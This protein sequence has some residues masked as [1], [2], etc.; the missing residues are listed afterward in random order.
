MFPHSN[1]CCP[2]IPDNHS[3]R[4]ILPRIV[5]RP[6]VTK[7][8][9]GPDKGAGG[10]RQRDSNSSRRVQY[11]SEGG[12]SEPRAHGEARHMPLLCCLSCQ[13]CK[14]NT[15]GCFATHKLIKG[16]SDV[17]CIQTINTADVSDMKQAI[18]T[19]ASEKQVFYYID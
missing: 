5:P 12:H 11:C 19:E 6:S 9:W 4:D 15:A 17:F 16:Q 1:S 8:R 18:N 3:I 14:N 2:L 10:R 7:T 13:A